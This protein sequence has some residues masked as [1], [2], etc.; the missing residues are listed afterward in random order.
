MRYSEEYGQVEE[1]KELEAMNSID[2]ETLEDI[3]TFAESLMGSKVV[4]M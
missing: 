2:I 3:N 1:M 4:N